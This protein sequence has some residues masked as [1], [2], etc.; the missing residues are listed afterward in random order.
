MKSAFYFW[1]KYFVKIVI[2][3]LIIYIPTQ[4]CIELVSVLLEK[5]EFP[6]K[7][8]NIIYN[9]IR[10]LIGY[11]ALLG[12]INFVVKI[13]ENNEEQTIKEVLI[14]GLKKWPKYLW[15]EIIASFKILI[16][17]ILLVIPGIY[18]SVKLS[19]IDCVVTTENNNGKDTLGKSEKLVE[20]QWWKVFGFLLLMSVFGLLFEAIFLPFYIF[21]PDSIPISFLIGV[22]VNVLE[23]Y[24][25]IVKAIYYLAMK[26]K[27]EFAGQ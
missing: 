26:D 8:Q 7:Y 24:F 19:F 14:H 1:K 5:T 25:F 21:F 22:V 17:S 11:I 20:N 6:L 15:F 23:T 12:I 2:I 13:S 4:I 16:Y 27:P 18:K 9:F 3:G 10:D